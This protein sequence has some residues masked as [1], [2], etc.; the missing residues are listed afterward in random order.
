MKLPSFV[1]SNGESNILVKGVTSYSQL[2]HHIYTTLTTT[3][4]S[5]A[6]GP[7]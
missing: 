1:T 6:N 4:G 7:K 3:I 2:K 5:F